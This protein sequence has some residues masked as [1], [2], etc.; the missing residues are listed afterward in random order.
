[1]ADSKKPQKTDTGHSAPAETPNDAEAPDLSGSPDS[2]KE[3]LT[4]PM[5]LFYSELAKI[6]KLG[7]EYEFN[8]TCANLFEHVKNI[9]E[10]S[11][12][13][14]RG[15]SQA[16][17]FLTMTEME[18][19]LVE[20]FTREHELAIF[21]FLQDLQNTAGES[22]IIRKKK[23]E[24]IQK[25]IRLRT[26]RA[27]KTSVVTL[28][29]RIEYTRKALIYSPSNIKVNPSLPK[30]KFIFPLDEALGLAHLPYKMTV[31]AMLEVSREACLSDSF[32]EAEQRLRQRTNI[33]IND[34]TIRK[35]T[36]TVGSIIYN[37]D[38]KR[39]ENLWNQTPPWKFTS[40]PDSQLNPNTLYLEI[41]GAMVHTR[42]GQARK[43]SDKSDEAI[44]LTVSLNQQC[45]SDQKDPLDQEEK[46]SSWK[47]N[48][49]GLA[50]STDNFL[51]WTDKHG[52][53]QHRILK[54]EFTALI[55][56]ATDFKKHF[57]SLALRNGYGKY[58]NTVMLSDGATWIR[59]M[60]NELFDNIIHILDYF[61]L[62]ENISNF[63]KNIF[64]VNGTEHQKWSKKIRHLIK[65][66][67]YQSAIKEIQSLGKRKLGQ[68]KFN[69]INYILNN[70]DS[71]NYKEYIE[72]GFFIGSG[73]IE[74][75]NRS[76]LQRRL[77]LPGMRWNIE[78]GQYIV[79]L[80]AK[81][82]SG[83]WANDVAEV[84][85]SHYGVKLRS[86]FTGPHGIG[87]GGKRT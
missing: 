68:S 16:E 45:N 86:S 76:V 61:H 49:L 80:M 57:Y 46:G 23:A 81:E 82:R 39:A 63:S 4:S 19:M 72:R 35:I 40:L 70:K 50:F 12:L 25:N 26:F 22:E 14:R 21:D 2:A 83:L 64:G 42:E 47:E 1:M 48:K 66:D 43:P 51:Y 11:Y 59:N 8:F 41:D 52:N 73:A 36:N 34:D 44:E 75:A 24:Y 27:Y 69:L 29:G 32:E 38:I 18:E 10:R 55:G 9:V 84:V 28:F 79:T 85:Y 37:N 78:T 65:Y 15:V 74:S 3:N 31:P 30:Q 67:S 7:E 87:F 13:L 71:I 77:K 56:T 6:A 33:S 58:K 17:N 62:C 60:K 20:Y 53:K 5:E 54:K